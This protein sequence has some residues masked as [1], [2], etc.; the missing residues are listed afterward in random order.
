MK[1]FTYN[2]YIKFIHRVRLNA[3][4]QVAEEKSKYNLEKNN[5][6][7][8]DKKEKNSTVKDEDETFIQQNLSFNNKI[9]EILK[10]SREVTEL[11]NTFLNPK[12]SINSEEIYLYENSYI[13]K[14]YSLK[15][16][17]IIYK[18]KNKPIF[19]LLKN[20]TYVDN[21]IN[22]KILNICVDIIQSWNK[23]N[24]KDSSAEQPLIVPIIIY[25]G[26]EILKKDTHKEKRYLGSYI[27]EK[28]EI[29]MEC[30]II[31]INEISKEKLILEN[32][33]FCKTILEHCYYLEDELHQILL[34]CTHSQRKFIYNVAKIVVETHFL[35][36]N[37]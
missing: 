18:N 12:R 6:T 27:L 26:S 29:D 7:E 14:K 24:K 19:Y 33:V 9:R 16:W 28:N 32:T 31:D 25:T 20:Q 11:I 4:L 2:Q 30:N 13:N 3:V 22:Y 23:N 34:K 8:D 35:K 15:E 36:P 5:N 1:V 21:E 17:F 10:D 37:K